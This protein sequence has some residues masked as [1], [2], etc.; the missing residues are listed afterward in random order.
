MFRLV[1]IFERNHQ[2]GNIQFIL[3][4]F[5]DDIAR[6]LD[7]S[8]VN[9]LEDFYGE[10]GANRAVEEIFKLLKKRNHQ[11]YRELSTDLRKLRQ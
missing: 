7:D 8:V 5:F 6:I 4:K 9:Q 1:Q 11:K 3:G 2:K 10:G